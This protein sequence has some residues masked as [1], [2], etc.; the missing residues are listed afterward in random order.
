MF[1]YVVD[2]GGMGMNDL[3]V[4]WIQDP[5]Q[6]FEEL[7]GWCETQFTDVPLFPLEAGNL[8]V[9]APAG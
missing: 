5:W 7:Q 3:A 1:A 8:V 4:T 6:P 2:G 9:R